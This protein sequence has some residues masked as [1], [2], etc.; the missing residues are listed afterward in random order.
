MSNTIQ[1]LTEFLAA[2]DKSRKYPANT[3][4]GIKAALRLFS[5]ELKDEEKESLDTFKAHFELIYQSVFNKNKARINVNSLGTYRRRMLGLLN[6][7]EKYGTDPAKMASWSRPV[8]KRLTKANVAKTDAKDFQTDGAG[9]E[10]TEIPGVPLHRVE[11]SLRPDAKAILLLPSDLT[12][13]EAEKIKGLVG[14]LATGE[15]TGEN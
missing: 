11:L 15:K 12:P 7:Y 5:E 8:V 9:E 3:V 13:E 10:K 1:T 2:A 14:Y 4:Y 6:D